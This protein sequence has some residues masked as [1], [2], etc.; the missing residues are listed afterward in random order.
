M[1]FPEDECSPQIPL[2]FVPHAHLLITTS[3]EDK[4]WDRFG[5]EICEFEYSLEKSNFRQHR[6]HSS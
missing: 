5:E 4:H 2:L 1:A 3:Y 6:R